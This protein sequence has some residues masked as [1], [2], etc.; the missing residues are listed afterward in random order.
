MPT[1]TG[2]NVLSALPEVPYTIDPA[3]FAQ[4]T[5]GNTQPLPVVPTPGNGLTAS[6]FLPKSG[7][8]SFLQLKFIGTLTVS[9]AGPI[10]GARWPYGLLSHFQLSAG[11]GAELFDVNGLDLSAL[12]AVNKPKL[13]SATVDQ[14]PGA[15]GGGGSAPAAGTYPLF[16]SYDIPIAV[17]QTSL[18]ASLFLQSSTATVQCNVTQENVA[19]LMESGGTGADWSISGNW[20]PSIRVWD[21]PVGSKGELILP[22]VNRVHLVAGINQPINGTGEQVAAV[23]RTAGILQRLF[24]RAEMSNIGPF[25]SALPSQA[26]SGLIDQISLNYGLTNTPLIYNPASLLASKNSDDYGGVLPYDTYV[27]DTLVQNPSRD[28]ILLQGVTNLQAHVYVD[29]AVTVPGGAYTRV[30]EEIL[31]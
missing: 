5:E 2:A 3:T 1:G 8:C 23:Q 7:V 31:V 27:I 18:I 15:V 6:F 22:E 20:Y 19:N 16:L 13:G 21:V 14:F 30:V 24:L 29:P 25:L 10:P 11:L 26:A 17:D 28:A 4:L 12:R 9:T